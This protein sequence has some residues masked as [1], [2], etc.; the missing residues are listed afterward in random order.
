ML[1]RFVLHNDEIRES[2]E[3]LFTAGQVGLFSGWGV[4]T[5]LRITQSVPF[6]FERHWNRMAKDAADFHITLPPDSGR[7]LGRL[8]DLIE[9]NQAHE[10]AM[11]L[12]VVRNHGG[13][14]A[15]RGNGRPSDLIA[16]TSAVKEWGP[17]AR[18]TYAPQ[19]RHSACRFSGAKILSWALNLTY[20]ENAQSAGFD[21]V[22]LLNE[23]G[24]LAEC[25]SANIFVVENGRA[26]T[27]PLESGCLPGVTRALLLSEVRAPG[28][29]VGERTLYP[30]DLEAAEEVFIT[31]T[32]RH[33]LPVLSID[34][35][36]TPE[37]RPV[38]EAL[39]RAYENYVQ[40]YT[41]RHRPARQAET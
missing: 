20:L 25:T 41:L 35:R 39:L 19:A 6:A 28:I 22:I 17:G 9:A 15:S 31:S 29:A 21:E 16:L 23:R 37:R 34:G 2:T 33:L 3:K 38:M 8:H 13:M 4:F 5:T 7:V 30:A 14:W 36:A 10:A 26:W 11:R 18:L 32:T 24:E 27:P 12:L 1:D 40:S